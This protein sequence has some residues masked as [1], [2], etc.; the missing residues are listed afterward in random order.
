M[1]LTSDLGYADEEAAREKSD[2]EHSPAPSANTAAGNPK[3][4]RSVVRKPSS[5]SQV[6]SNR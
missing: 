2:G 6:T 1:V 5:S 3:G 4:A